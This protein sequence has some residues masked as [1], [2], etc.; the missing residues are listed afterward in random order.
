MNEGHISALAWMMKCSYAYLWSASDLCEVLDDKSDFCFVETSAN[1]PSTCVSLHDNN[2]SGLEVAG[3]FL[4][5]VVIQSFEWSSVIN[6]H[7]SIIQNPFSEMKLLMLWCDSSQWCTAWHQ[8]HLKLRLHKIHFASYQAESV[9]VQLSSLDD[10][11]VKLGLSL[12]WYGAIPEKLSFLPS[13]L[14]RSCN[15]PHRNSQRSERYLHNTQDILQLLTQLRLARPNHL[16]LSLHHLLHLGGLQAAN[17]LVGLLCLV[18]CLGCY[19][20]KFNFIIW[21]N[22][23]HLFAK[24]GIVEANYLSFPKFVSENIW[25]LTRCMEDGEDIDVVYRLHGYVNIES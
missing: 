8:V 10:Q 1:H 17:H 19:G 15:F 6:T 25:W 23:C 2:V 14:E 3:A 9:L 20:N 21:N 18:D 24:W 11:C 5:T 16:R 13:S 12:C 22:S 4:Q 7:D